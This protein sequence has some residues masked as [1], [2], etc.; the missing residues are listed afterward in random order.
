MTPSNWQQQLAKFIKRIPVL[1]GL[2]YIVYRF[3]QP[4]YTIGVVGVII[5]DEGRVLFVEHVFHPKKPWGIPGGW[6]GRDEDPA[7]AVLREIREEL[8]LV[9]K[10]EKL[11][12]TKKTQRLHIDIAFLC[13]PDGEVGKLSYELL[14]YEWRRPEDMPPLHAFHQ[15]AV[16]EGVRVFRSQQTANR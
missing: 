4:K 5:N 15:L 6:I 14:R 8:Q 7:V 2:A 9:A 3:F 1:F 13:S 11:L 12:L 10:I 16:E